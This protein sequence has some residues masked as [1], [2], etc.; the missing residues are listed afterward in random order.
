MDLVYVYKFTRGLLDCA[1]KDVGLDIAKNITRGSGVRLY[2]LRPINAKSAAM[3][4]FR[5]AREWNAL[6]MAIVS[7]KSLITFKK[8]LNDYL[9]L[10][11]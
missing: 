2:Q 9:M 8:K 1:A 3:F 6:P 10:K 11:N 7:C 5:A 4:K